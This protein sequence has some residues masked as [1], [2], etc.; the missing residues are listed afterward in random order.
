MFGIKN[1]IRNYLEVNKTITELSRC[2]NRELDDM[3]INRSD[4]RNIAMGARIK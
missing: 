2:T 3:G 1:K 4:I